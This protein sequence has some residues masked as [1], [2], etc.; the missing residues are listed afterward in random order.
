MLYIHYTFTLPLEYLLKQNKQK[1]TKKKR[2][3]NWNP[4]SPTPLLLRQVFYLNA[5]NELFR[6]EIA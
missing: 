2:K 1:K 5:K 4:L 6:L 3:Q